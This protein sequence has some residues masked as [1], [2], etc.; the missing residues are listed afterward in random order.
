MK[1]WIL[2]FVLC[3]LLIACGSSDNEA[4]RRAI[5]YIEVSELGR[6]QL[7]RISG[8]VEAGNE[9]ELSFQVSGYVTSVLVASGDIVQADQ[10]LATL[11]NKPYQ[12]NLDA[13]KADWI[14]ANAILTE[15]KADHDAKATLF[16]KK[17]VSKTMMDAARAEYE[18]AQQNIESAKAKQELAQRDLDNTV[19]KAPFA[20][21]IGSVKVNPGVNV[22]AGQPLFHLLGKEGFEVSVSLPE[23]LRKEVWAGLPVQIAFPS[24]GESRRSGEIS[25]LAAAT[26]EGNA[27]ITKIHVND[28]KGLYPGLTA[29]VWIEFGHD[30]AS[31]QPTYLI[32]ASALVPASQKGEAYVFVYDKT[33]ETVKKTIVSVKDIRENSVEVVS[34]L[35]PGDIV[36]TAG[37]HFLTDGQPVTL[38]QEH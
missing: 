26:H 31:K 5:Q 15:K 24:L 12:L 18:S 22:G 20:G 35:Q 23:G 4:P 30:N 33:S 37:V 29:E 32:P 1:K 28:G 25:E 3:S 19:L 10:T 9:A 16:E 34:G 27:F 7:R 38:Y 8:V 14:K 13:A 6:G 17:F 2:S 36:A 21:D 11:D